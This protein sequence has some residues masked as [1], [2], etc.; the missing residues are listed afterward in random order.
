MDPK[1]V[2]ATV[3]GLSSGIGLLC[4]DNDSL[5]F[6]MGSFMIGCGVAIIVRYAATN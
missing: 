4:T 3:L 6:G 1:N 5:V 2:V